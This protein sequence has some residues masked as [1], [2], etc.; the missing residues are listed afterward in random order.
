MIAETF[1]QRPILQAV[2]FPAGGAD[3]NRRRV[4]KAEMH[5]ALVRL[6]KIK[7]QDRMP[8]EL[9]QRIRLIRNRPLNL[10]PLTTE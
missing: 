10:L 8:V 5:K 1:H 9:T 3:Q 4:K 2:F 7:G 6:Q